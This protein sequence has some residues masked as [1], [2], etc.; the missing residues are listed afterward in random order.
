[1]NVFFMIASAHFLALLSPGQD[2]I[3]LLRNSTASGFKAGLQTTCGITLA[4]G[5]WIIFALCFVNQIH[6]WSLL[7]QIMRWVGSLLL[8]YIGYLFFKNSLSNNS[9]DLLS[10]NNDNPFQ[11]RRIHSSFGLGLFSGLS[12]PKNGLFYVGL[13][14][15]G[16]TANASKI[17]LFLY[18]LWMI[19]VG[20]LWDALIVIFLTRTKP[21]TFIIQR[22]YLI[23]RISGILL[24]CIGVWMLIR[25]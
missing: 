13:F 7:L 22:Q 6:S 9:L 5:L 21:R 8:I 23:E 11:L 10:A 20:F 3:L 25:Q 15:L 18:G 16:S 4:N 12:N 14:S 24:A 2:F 19:S 1:M 17:T